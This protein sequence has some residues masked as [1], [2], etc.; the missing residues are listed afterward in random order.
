LSAVESPSVGIL[1]WG[2]V[3][4]DFLEPTGMTLEQYAGEFVGSWV[5]AWARAL[6]TAGVRPEIVCV[7]R[8]ASAEARM[9]HGPTGVPLVVLPTTRLYRAIDRRMAYPYGESARQVFGQ[10]EEPRGLRRLAMELAREIGPYLATPPFRTARAMRSGRWRAL[11]C[12]EYEYPRFDVSVLLGAALRVPVFGVFQGGV[13]RPGRV[14]A[15]VRPRTTARAAGLIVGPEREVDRIRAEYP[16]AAPNIV[17]VVNPIDVDVWRPGDRDAPRRELGIEPEARVVA[18]HG[19][20]AVHHKGLDLLLEAWR[21]I[22]E[23][24]EGNER[25]LLIGGGSDSA[26]VDHLVSR[27]GLHRV[28]RVDRHIHDAGLLSRYLSAADAYVLSSRHE[29]FPVALIEAMSCGLPVVAADVAGAEEIVGRDGD[30]AGIVI[31]AG[32]PGA[33]ADAVIELLGDAGLRERLAA[34]GRARA[35]E[36]FSLAAVG[37][38]L[39]ELILSS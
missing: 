20:V 14:E 34:R 11:L 2:N 35:E 38:Q 21:A 33:I 27:L 29:G 24:G 30:A 3:V 23:R 18:W 26:A 9:T 13:H 15:L 28:T 32:A 4:E 37:E 31:P 25:L 19:R 6:A 12:Q 1:P 5:F 17:R 16:A 22:E 7:S 36:R 10:D 8:E 39:R